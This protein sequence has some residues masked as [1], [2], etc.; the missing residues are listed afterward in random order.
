MIA[1]TSSRKTRLLKQGSLSPEALIVRVP[2]SLSSPEEQHCVDPR[3]LLPIYDG[4][5]QKQGEF[6]QDYSEL[7]SMF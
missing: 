3:S 1:T 5:Q 4:H 2:F 6:P 7:E